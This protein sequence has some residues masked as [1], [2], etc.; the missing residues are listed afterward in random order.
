MIMLLT[1]FISR[2][3]DKP[4]P[5]LRSPALAMALMGA[6][7]LVSCAASVTTSV[8]TPPTHSVTLTWMASTSLVIGYNA[9]RG[10]QSGGPYTR[11][12]PSLIAT[13][14][15]ID[16]TVQA[17]QTYYYVVTAVDSDNTESVYSNQASVTIPNP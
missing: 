14:T 6:L 9:Y 16:S 4:S 12:N 15:Y 10:T 2:I 7:A 8:T 17:G 3:G 1:H 5:R 11:L 13:T